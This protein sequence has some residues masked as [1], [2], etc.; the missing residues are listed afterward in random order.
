[1]RAVRALSA[2][3]VSAVLAVGS[4]GCSGG[5]VRTGDASSEAGRTHPQD[6]LAASAAVMTK[7][8]N[9]RLTLV[10]GGFGDG[11]GQ[12]TWK[13]PRTAE[14]I[15]AAPG[16]LTLRLVAQSVYNGMTE[17]KDSDRISRWFRV[18]I[19]DGEGDRA[20]RTAQEVALFQLLN[21]CLHLT[22]AAR[23]NDITTVGDEQ[24]DGVATV[25]YRS[26]VPAPT[27]T[28][29]MT[30]LTATQRQNTLA[31]LQHEGGY[32]TVD[33][34]INGKNEDVQHQLWLPGRTDGRR[35][36][37]RYTGLGT[38]STVQPPAATEV[39]DMS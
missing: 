23:S 18:D 28:D 29:A 16:K 15:S 24:I 4:A 6:V 13:D 1:M 26:T 7:A 8:G 21:P 39:V 37:V 12:Y 14:L 32:V 11:T 9:A 38:A 22:V 5:P 10:G 27:L 36:T 35:T 33:I 25:H 31:L 17:T 20:D 34:W 2:A 3:V 30:G 19:V